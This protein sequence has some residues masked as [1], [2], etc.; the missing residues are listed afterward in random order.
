M[1]RLLYQV[2]VA[3]HWGLCWAIEVAIEW[4]D[5]LNRWKLMVESELPELLDP[6]EPEEDSKFGDFW[7]RLDQEEL[8]ICKGRILLDEQGC[9]LIHL[10]EDVPVTK[11]AAIWTKLFQESGACVIYT[12]S[13]SKATRSSIQWDLVSEEWKC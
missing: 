5:N 1:L 6:D 12:I 3:V 2:L 4:E 7:E 10:S 11:L 13:N 9:A 8:E